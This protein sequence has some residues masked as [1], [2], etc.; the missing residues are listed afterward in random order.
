MQVMVACI[1]VSSSDDDDDGNNGD[2]QLGCSKQTSR[3]GNRHKEA[4]GKGLRCP[5][6]MDGPSTSSGGGGIIRTGGRHKGA[7][8]SEPSFSGAGTGAK[9]KSRAG[10]RHKGIAGSDKSSNRPSVIG[11]GAMQKK[12]GTYKRAAGGGPSF[13]DKGSRC[14]DGDRSTSIS[15]GG[16]IGSK[17][18]NRDGGKEAAGG[19]RSFSCKGSSGHTDE[20][21]AASGIRLGGSGMTQGINITIGGPHGGIKIGDK[22][23]QGI[24]GGGGGAPGG[25]TISGGGVQR[26][27]S[28]GSSYGGMPSWSSVCTAHGPL[29]GVGCEEQMAITVI[30]PTQSKSTVS[31]PTQSVPQQSQSAIFDLAQSI[32]L[33]SQFTV[34]SHTQSISLQSQSTVPAKSIPHQ[35]VYLTPSV[36]HQSQL[37]QS[38]YHKKRVNLGLI[39][40]EGFSNVSYIK[41]CALQHTKS[42]KESD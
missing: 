8:G 21:N 4:A 7:A 31:S 3:D 36:P 18:K 25:I 38:F 23:M 40:R 26:G 5:D 19:G 17:Q 32:P 28:I 35:V 30:D 37:V 20:T 12:S 33:Q 27:T 42:L 24:G 11:I 22:E 9:Q 13:S 41:K 10:G 6:S 1:I 15:S 2:E 29:A 34:V 16:G 39:A 14:T